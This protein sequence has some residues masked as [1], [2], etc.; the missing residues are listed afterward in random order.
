M[1]LHH[2][3]GMKQVKKSVFICAFHNFH[4]QPNGQFQ[5]GFHTGPMLLQYHLIL[6]CSMLCPWLAFS[7]LPKSL[8][9]EAPPE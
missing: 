5:T 3:G 1:M 8:P 2:W 6:K 7:A 9:L 4:V